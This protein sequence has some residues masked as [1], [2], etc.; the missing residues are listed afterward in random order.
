[1]ACLGCIC[2]R[3][4]SAPI[5]GYRNVI[6]MV[7]VAAVILALAWA[8][9][10]NPVLAQIAEIN[11]QSRPDLGVALPKIVTLYPMYRT[12]L[13]VLAAG[14]VIFSRRKA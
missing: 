7:L 13:L 8:W 6:D 9:F 10:Y 11:A 12:G 5:A 4:S 3:R 14:T 2:R 1:M